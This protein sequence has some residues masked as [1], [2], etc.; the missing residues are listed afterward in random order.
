MK[1]RVYK[2]FQKVHFN[3]AV[4][5]LGG[6]ETIHQGHLQLIKTAKALKDVDDIVV[7]LISNPSDLPNIRD[8][9]IMQLEVRLDWLAD[10]GIKHIVVLNFH[11]IQNLEAPYFIKQLINIGAK[12]LIVGEDYR[13]GKNAAWDA[14]K[15]QQYFNNTIIVELLKFNNI[16]ISSSLLKESI[17][18][19]E[20]DYL[21][22]FLY[23]PYSINITR[24]ADS[25]EAYWPENITQLAKG[26][27][28]ANLLFANKEFHGIVKIG[29]NQKLSF[30]ILDEDFDTINT[31]DL[32]IEFLE[33][34][35]TII[36]TERDQ[37]TEKDTENAMNFF[38]KIKNNL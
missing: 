7:F 36:S 19:G 4:F 38:L 22:H 25:F 34:S 32:R 10:L 15:L 12:Y 11:E 30:K 28:F 31:S 1:T 20:L 13:L 33:K 23:K 21:N 18:F 9:N 29:F 17:I 6:F 3:N 2:T 35:R 14:E 26:I 5:I 24:I 8:G 37:I 16:K 27:Y